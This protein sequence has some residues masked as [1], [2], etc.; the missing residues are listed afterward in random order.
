MKKYILGIAAL[1]CTMTISAQ[2]ADQKAEAA[3]QKAIASYEAAKKKLETA[4]RKAF[5]ADSLVTKGTD[6][7]STWS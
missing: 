4:N 6:D 5:I 3:K 2:S 7:Y 1:L